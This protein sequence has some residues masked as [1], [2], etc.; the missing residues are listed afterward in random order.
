MDRIA[1]SLMIE[2]PLTLAVMAVVLYTTHSIVWAT[3][4]LAVVWGLQL[5][6]YDIPSA[7][8]ILRAQSPG[9]E[10]ELMRPRFDFKLIRPLVWLALPLGLAATLTSLNA[11]IPRYIIEN[12][13]GKQQLGY[14]LH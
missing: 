10:W 14:L 7:R 12:Y 13:L 2:G 1:K 4:S 3:G 11:N 6:F 8:L 9:D 5:T